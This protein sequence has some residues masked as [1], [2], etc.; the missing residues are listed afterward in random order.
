MSRVGVEKGLCSANAEEGQGFMSRR[1]QLF[2]LVTFEN[3]VLVIVEVGAR[4][5]EI[6][7]LLT[8]EGSKAGRRI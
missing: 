3:A 5:Q 7:F 8:G 1:D 2:H 4:L 6:N